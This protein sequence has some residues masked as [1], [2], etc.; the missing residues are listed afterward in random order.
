[1]SELEL[2]SKQCKLSNIEYIPKRIETL[3]KLIKSE[4]EL[5]EY[6]FVGKYPRNTK[7]NYDRI[8]KYHSELNKLVEKN[9]TR[10]MIKDIKKEI[11]TLEDEIYV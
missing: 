4:E 2:F 10:Q 3:K 9:V 1:M 7:E 11:K 5:I 6:L 8:Q